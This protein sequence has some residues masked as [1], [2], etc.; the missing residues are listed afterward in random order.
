MDERLQWLVK[1]CQSIHIAPSSRRAY[2]GLQRIYMQCCDAFDYDPLLVSEEELCKV[3][4]HFAL[5]HT[6]V[7]VPGYLSAIQDLYNG[8]GAGQ[9]PRGQRFVMFVKGLNRLLG[10]ADVVVRTRALG[11][12][13]LEAILQSLDQSD[14]SEVSFGAQLVV[15]FMLALRTED[16]TDG[17]LRWGD[18]YPQAD[19]SVEF[20]LPPGKSVKQFRRV[21]IAAN[22]GVLSAAGWLARLAAMLPPAAKLANRPVF[23]DLTMLPNGSARLIALSRSKFITRFK[24]SVME[25]L[26]FNPE[27]YAGYSLRRGGVT[28]MLSQ[29]IPLPVVKRH[30]GWTPLSDA[31]MAYYDHHGRLQMRIPTAMM[32]RRG[33]SS[34]EQAPGWL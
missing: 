21:A 18:V 13:E 20:L 26:G 24:L 22:P 33:A 9:L 14:P 10:A 7:S 2:Q 4:A 15:A 27:L 30:V 32:G 19:G 12:H 3:V 6:V 34:V 28:E 8:A 25:V 29:D 1:L 17:R 31:V 11:V 23:V 5:G 16:H